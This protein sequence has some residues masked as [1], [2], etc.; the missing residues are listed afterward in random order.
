[1]EPC[2][3][4]A[5]ITRHARGIAQLGSALR[6]GRR[7]RR[8]KSGYPDSVQGRSSTRRTGPEPFSGPS[9][10]RTAL[11][12]CLSWSNAPTRRCRQRPCG[13]CSAR[14]PGRAS[15]TSTSRP[16]CSPPPGRCAATWTSS[17]QPAGPSRRCGAAAPLTA[18]LQTAPMASAGFPPPVGADLRPTA[19]A[20]CAPPRRLRHPRPGGRRRSVPARAAARPC[21]P[22]P[23]DRRLGVVEFEDRLRPLRAGRHPRR[24]GAPRGAVRRPGNARDA[25]VPRCPAGRRRR[26][27]RTGPDRSTSTGSRSP[28]TTGAGECGG[29]QP[30]WIVVPG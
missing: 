5:T 17:L 28:S 8:F 18:V 27:R 7:G 19:P 10:A 26:R 6:S 16:C 12:P 23:Q 11:P 21:S 25:A 30:S 1:M 22:K 14:R 3:A 2:R 29:D 24:Q 20:T 9:G 4:W 13:P 15:R